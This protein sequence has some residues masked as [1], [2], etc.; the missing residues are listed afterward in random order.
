M[1]MMMMANLLGSEA[2]CEEKFFYQSICFDAVYLSLV[3][4]G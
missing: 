1:M 2:I 4:H 3:W